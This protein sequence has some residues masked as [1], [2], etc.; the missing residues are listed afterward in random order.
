MKKVIIIRSI[1][2]IEPRTQ[3]TI[4]ILHKAGYIVAY[5]SLDRDRIFPKYEKLPN[6]DIKRFRIKWFKRSIG[7]IFVLPIWWTYIFF[8]L[9]IK[10]YDYA[11]CIDLDTLPPTFLITKIRRKKLVY[12]IFDYAPDIYPDSFGFPSL[13]ILIKKIEDFFISRVNGLILVDDIRLEQVGEDILKKCKHV[14]IIYNSPKDTFRNCE[15]KNKIFTIFYGGILEKDRGIYYLINAVSELTNVE[16]VLAGFGKMEREV[17]IIAS[18]SP[19]IK[20]LGKVDHKTIIKNTEKAHLIPCLYSPEI[21]NN[22]YASPNKFFESLMLGKPSIAYEET[23]FS[24]RLRNFNCG[25]TIVYKNDV[26]AQIRSTIKDLICDKTKYFELC[27]NARKA[28]LDNYSDNRNEFVL[29]KLY[30]D[31]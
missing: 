25:I 26:S 2:D 19:N 24:R 27:V 4:E 1:A 5:L 15:N 21:P 29:Q 18:K 31:L 7:S 8:T 30:K 13:R 12:E 28:Y 3:R 20:F 11:H 22:I 14:D 17:K 9:M 6:V 23:I 10:N 16:L